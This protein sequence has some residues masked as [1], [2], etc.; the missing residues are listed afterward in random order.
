MNRVSSGGWGEKKVRRKRIVLISATL[1]P[2]SF[3]VFSQSLFI[4]YRPGVEL[5]H[6]YQ[7]TAKVV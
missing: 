4:G 5:S 7:S 1:L 2:V 3:W 6:K